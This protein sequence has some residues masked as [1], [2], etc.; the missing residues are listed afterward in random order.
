MSTMSLHRKYKATAQIQL[1]LGL[2]LTMPAYMPAAFSE[3]LPVDPSRLVSA[4]QLQTWNADKAAGGPTFS[5]SPAWL[6]HMNFIEAE[7]RQRGV[8]DLLREPLSYRRWFAPD[9]PTPIAM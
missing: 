7:L 9:R 8:V 1:L 5:G 4:A 3:A 6:T 2:L